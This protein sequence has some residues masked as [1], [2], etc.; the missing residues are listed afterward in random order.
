MRRCVVLNV[1]GLSASL[2]G[3][4]MPRL[5]RFAERGGLRFVGG[6]TP[7]VTCTVQSTYLTGRLPREHGV[8]ANGW[9]FRDLD[10]V[11]L[12]RQSNRLV[13]GDKVWHEGRR[14]DPAFTCASTFWWFNRPI[15]VDWSVTPL[16]LYLADGRKLPDCASD[17]PELRE[18]LTRSLGTFPLFRFWG[19]ATDLSAT[20]WIAQSALYIE[21]QH[22]PTLQLVY[23]P[24]LDYVLQREGPNGRIENDLMEIDGVCGE[25]VDTLERA[26]CR[27]I[28]VSE[29]GIGAVRGPCH[30]NRAL[31]NAGLLAVKQDLG[32]EV[33]D[34]GRSRAFAV[35]DHQVA[36][37]YV[38]RP[39]DLEPTRRVLEALPE[40]ERVLDRG[41]Q[42][43][44]GLDHERSGELVLIARPD[45][46]FT[47]YYWLDDALAPDFA[48]IV[49]IHAKPGYDPCELFVDPALRFPKAKIAWTLLRKKLGFRSLLELI[50][51]DANLVRGSHGRVPDDPEEGALLLGG[52]PGLLPPGPLAPTALRE[53]ILRH[54][55][56]P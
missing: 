2:L 37:V 26:G 39:A 15:D 8:V 5:T 24:H 52:D 55:F 19:P 20:R 12:W 11:W 27:V 16:P 32:R 53:L 14:R 46:W 25:L 48:R 50:P 23:L 40:V 4:R 45:R 49:D 54:V 51:L 9:Y 38:Q 43:A 30:P 7:A 33:L 21:G 3:P 18:Q 22:R 44:L 41:E 29:Y 56:E 47:Y 36:H 1:V 28:V 31:R 13:Q 17:P 6:V 34:T 10:K 42:A 35:A